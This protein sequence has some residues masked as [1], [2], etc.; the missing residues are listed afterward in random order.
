MP[1]VRQ[2]T[3]QQERADCSTR[4]AWNKGTKSHLDILD[5]ATGILLQIGFESLKTSSVCLS[6]RDVRLCGWKRKGV[7]RWGKD[8][9]WLARIKLGRAR[10]G[11]AVGRSGGE[12]SWDDVGVQLLCL[13]L[14]LTLAFPAMFHNHWLVMIARSLIRHRTVTPAAAACIVAA[15]VSTTV[16]IAS[17][18][19]LTIAVTVTVL[20]LAARIAAHRLTTRF[21]S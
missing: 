12:R 18:L 21:P 11:R 8:D 20:A 10:L 5:K 6:I 16:V 13:A 15:A 19:T 3:S 9:C 2:S 7:A 17:T 14:P 1:T 4:L